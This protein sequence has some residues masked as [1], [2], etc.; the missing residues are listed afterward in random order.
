M[1]S[2]ENDALLNDLA[3]GSGVVKPMDFDRFETLMRDLGFYW[4][5]WNQIPGR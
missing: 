4:L 3:A 2:I 1:P 5:T